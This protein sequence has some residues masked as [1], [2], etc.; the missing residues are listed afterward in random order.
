MKKG[1]F[2]PWLDRIALVP[3]GSVAYKFARVAAGAAEATFTPQPRNA[4]DIAG[5][6][7]IVEAAGGRTSDCDGQPF[8]C[9][10]DPD[11][12]SHRGVCAT[13]GLVHDEIL[14]MVRA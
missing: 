13:N 8:R 6:V 4:W 9:F 1:M 5:G 14:R 3:L 10:A 11:P 2:A 7:A 12:L